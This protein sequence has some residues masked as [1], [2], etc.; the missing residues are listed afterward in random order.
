MTHQ[1][2]K[3]LQISVCK[4]KHAYMFDICKLA[5]YIIMFLSNLCLQ[6]TTIACRDDNNCIIIIGISSIAYTCMYIYIFS[7]LAMYS[8]HMCLAIRKCAFMHIVIYT[9]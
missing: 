7:Y 9:H 5:T 3:S 4:Y 2:T 8:Q 1:I 6:N